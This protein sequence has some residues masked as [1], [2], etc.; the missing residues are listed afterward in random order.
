[1]SVKSF[2]FL[3]VGIIIAVLFVGLAW[4]QPPQAAGG[5]APPAN[6]VGRFQMASE[7]GHVYILDTT[8]GEVW[9]KFVTANVGSDDDNFKKPKV[10]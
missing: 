6:Q 5:C 9:E 10:K 1:M 8:T 4:R 7:L 3:T 2:S